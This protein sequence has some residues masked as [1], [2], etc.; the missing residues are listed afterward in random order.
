MIDDEPKDASNEPLEIKIIA[1]ASD[2]F[3]NITPEKCQRI[4]ELLLPFIKKVVQAE[5]MKPIPISAAKDISQRYGYDQIVVIG[6]RVGEGEHVTTYGR[7]K[8]NCDVAAKIGDFIKFKIMG[9]P[10]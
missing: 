7:D 3:V 10:E 2:G 4:R 8:A 9:W 5:E 6:R 1:A